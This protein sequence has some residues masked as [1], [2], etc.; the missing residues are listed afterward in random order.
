MDQHFFYYPV[1]FNTLPEN[2][3]KKKI[4]I[5]SKY[6][7]VYRWGVNAR[8]L[9]NSREVLREI[10]KCFSHFLSVFANRCQIL[11][12]LIDAQS[13]MTKFCNHKTSQGLCMIKLWLVTSAGYIFLK[14]QARFVLMGT[15]SVDGILNF[16]S[17]AVN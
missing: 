1:D 5:N 14:K 9:M 15:F 8:N 11:M 10:S 7:R 17:K 13:S 4:K 16:S 12:S 6:H 2:T 3:T